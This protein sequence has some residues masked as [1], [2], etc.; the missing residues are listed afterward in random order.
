MYNGRIMFRDS[1]YIFFSDKD[2]TLYHFLRFLYLMRDRMNYRKMYFFP[3]K[4]LIHF[5][6]SEVLETERET[7]MWKLVKNDHP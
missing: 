3:L 5:S 7:I 1:K 2:H 6:S 4:N